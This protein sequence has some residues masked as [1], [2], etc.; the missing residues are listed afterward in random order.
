VADRAICRWNLAQLIM[1]TYKIHEDAASH[2]A[3]L[4][5]RAQGAL[6]EPIEGTAKL[7]ADIYTG[8]DPSAGSRAAVLGDQGLPYEQYV[9]ATKVT[10]WRPPQ[11]TANLFLSRVRQIV[12]ALT[13]GVPSFDV[14]AMI[15][16]AANQA[17]DQNE[18]TSWQVKHGG[19][20][21]A[22]RRT[23]FEGLLSPHFGTKLVIDKK[24]K[25]DYQKLSFLAVGAMDCGY[26]PY[27]RRF[28]WH[29]Y[30]IQWGDL[31]DAWKPKLPSG[32]EPDL[33]ATVSVTEVYHEGFKFGHKKMG[34]YPM[35]IF[36]N[37][38]RAATKEPDGGI[39]L[40]A[41]ADESGEEL[42]EYVITEDLAECPLEVA[43]FL[44]P[45]PNEDIAP[46]EVLSWI[47]LMRMIV[48]TLV[49]INREITTK[50]KTVLYDKNAISDDT[51]SLI[52]ESVPGATIFA[53][54]DVD[55]AQRGVN[56]TMRPVEQDSVLSEYI[57]SL[58]TY[59]SLFDDV[60]G[61]GPI[62]RGVPANPRKSA[63][64]ASSIVAASNRR[65][66]DRLEILARVWGTMAQ[67]AHAFQRDVY[68]DFIEVPLPSGLS[69]VIA[70]PEKTAAAFT[71][72]VDPVE[73]GHLSKRG[74]VDTYFNWLTT[75]TNTLNVFQGGMPR[76]VR[77]ALR[78][79]GKA[80]GVEDVDLFLE[81]PNIE[82]G[83]EDRYI[84]YITGAAQEIE[85]HADDQH[86]MY[87]A[88]YSKILE[89][90]MATAN[91]QAGPGE[92]RRAIDKH[93][94]FVMQQQAAMQ[95]QPGQ[96]PVPGV[97]AEGETDNQIM[98]AL[99][100]GMAPPAT[101]QTLR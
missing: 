75:I 17:S 12:T 65:N 44:E 85:V 18:I 23:A 93:N 40:S 86:E 20:T 89:K 28:K 1:A 91:P 70:V 78:R 14:R 51:I 19:L 100:A 24:A 15:P 74:E 38:G 95:G 2:L 99:Q 80:M 83:P 66:R 22:M 71:F 64:E 21:E 7:I 6:A 72:R 77:E 55:D 97:N 41:L 68:G 61:V 87:I 56:A 88:Y 9:E 43:S 57:A 96:A 94:T 58:N 76:M 73:L 34:D 81:M 36:V 8:R 52:Q 37:M 3:D 60:T 90:A 101:P 16:G 84:A 50:N 62:D 92:L 98:A 10:T 35:S 11:T 79:M 26:E 49:Q 47:P 63:T 46:A 27:H 39:P 42:G 25:Y 54:V 4:V 31:P 82:A 5:V 45:A 53:G 33:W 29:R 13:P 32:D 69:R 59:L 67:K 30:D 48:Q